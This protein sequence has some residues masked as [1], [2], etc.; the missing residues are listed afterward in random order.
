LEDLGSRFFEIRQWIFEKFRN[1]VAFG[2]FYRPW[3]FQILNA[4]PSEVKEGRMYSILPCCVFKCLKFLST[5]AFVSLKFVNEFSRN[6][7][8]LVAFWT[9]YRPWKFHILNAMF[10]EVM[11]GWMY[12]SL[13]QLAM[14]FNAV[15]LRRLRQSDL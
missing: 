5:W 8:N 7:G 10:F 12:S 4:M 15:K 2:I 6:S 14:Y 13:F 11:E 1:L 9:L 3:K